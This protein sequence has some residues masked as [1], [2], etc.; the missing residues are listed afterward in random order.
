MKHLL[1]VDDDSFM[2][3]LLSA[4]FADKY[5]LTL[6]TTGEQA[7]EKARQEKPDL[8]LLDLT[9]PTMS[10]FDVLMAVREDVALQNTPVVVFSNTDDPEVQTKT[11]EMGAHSYYVKASTELNDLV[12][13]VDACF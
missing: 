3:D 2:L 6:A 9:L 1:I 5:T 12:T 11:M 13:A 8:I 7:L 10:G 4:R